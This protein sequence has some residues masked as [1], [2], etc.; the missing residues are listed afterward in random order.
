MFQVTLRDLKGNPTKTFEV[1]KETIQVSPSN[2]PAISHHVVIIDRSG[3]MY[4]DIESVRSVV[5]K[6]A[7]L[8]EYR[9]SGLLFSVV[10]YSSSGDCTLHFS[11]QPLS[12]VM[13]PGSAMV[14]QIRSIR[15]TGLTCMSQAVKMGLDQVRQDEP[16]VV[17]LHSDGY[18]NDP[19]PKQEQKQIEAL[20]DDAKKN[21]S[22]LAFDT[23][24]YSDRSD[25]RLLLS[26]SERM[27][28][29]CVVARD[30][31]TV[32]DALLET[33]KRLAEGTT[34]PLQ[35]QSRS[36]LV[37][38]VCRSAGKVL[39]DT[40][41]VTVRGL[42]AGETV[43]VFRLRLAPA[44]A[45][46]LDPE[47]D[48]GERSRTAPAPAPAP[49]SASVLYGLSMAWL[50]KGQIRLA[51]EALCATRDQI[52]QTHWR[53]LSRTDLQAFFEDVSVPVLSGEVIHRPRTADFGVL[54]QGASIL[55]LF[56]A[57]AEH[58]RDLKVDLSSMREGYRLKSV[59]KLDGSRDEEGN[60]VPP[61]VQFNA[62][63]EGQWVKVSG[64]QL[65]NENATLNLRT[66]RRGRLVPRD[67]VKLEHALLGPDGSISSIAA[68]DLSDLKVFRNFT[69]VSDGCV[70][71]PQI[72]LQ[73]S[74]KS[75]WLAL[76][77]LGVAQGSFLPGAEVNVNLSAMPVV[78]LGTRMDSSG[79]DGAVR[80]LLIG[81]MLSS[82]LRA[83]SVGTSARFSDE[84]VKAL[85]AACVTPNLYV[86]IPSTVPYTDLSQALKD[87]IV[88]VEVGTSVQVGLHE[89]LPSQLPSANEFL[90]RH[91]SVFQDGAEIKGPKFANLF[92]RGVIVDS[93]E[94][95]SRAKPTVADAM[96][97]PFFLDLFG[98]GSEVKT[99]LAHLGVS[100][101][102]SED[103]LRCLPKLPSHGNFSQVSDA[104]RRIQIVA[105][106]QEIVSDS[107]ESLLGTQ[108]RPLVFWVGATGSLPDGVDVPAL[109]AEQAKARC[110]N[111]KVGKDLS[112]ASF[113]F[114]PGGVLLAAV[115]EQRYYSL[116]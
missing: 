29:R 88:D 73:V 26:F 91:F 44:T 106:V 98:E 33:Q 90:G 35:I 92:S 101:E 17:T 15:S 50:Q 83:M 80:Q 82:I 39:L 84:Q 21:F 53:A 70:H 56:S 36:D 61:S 47:S 100:R 30:A 31:R 112:E 81:K 13:K 34:P 69:V 63:D 102:L 64:I 95:S 66:V 18:C 38:V 28:G 25:F 89:L 72:C 85:A 43:D 74:S 77:R 57:M 103:L 86:S 94:L 41:D 59:R 58:K 67:G 96:F 65:S 79:L 115:P 113:Y 107:M 5:E 105:E 93:K 75:A 11:R 99:I 40:S 10:S 114:L 62:I 16:T 22:S 51:K 46:S 19:S 7:V 108:I 110:P 4:G 32:Y 111:L 24:A 78:D 14:E 37:L 3:S 48:G 27:G 55:E 6:V 42:K 104:E 116:R 20:L 109:D 12:E 2:K 1:H 9:D 45:G 54:A 52:Y 71:L 76:S 23:V 68:V 97:K 60:L 8:E 49:D 87:G